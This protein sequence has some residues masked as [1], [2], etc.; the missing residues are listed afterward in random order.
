MGENAK[1][2]SPHRRDFA[3][4]GRE[5]FLSEKSPFLTS[6]KEAFTDPARTPPKQV[7]SPASQQKMP[8]WLETN[9]YA[10]EFVGTTNIQTPYPH[11]RDD[12]KE[13]GH[14]QSPERLRR[15]EKAKIP[16]AQIHMKER[17]WKR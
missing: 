10:D 14:T 4:K 9:R 15:A 3:A 5:K 11:L 17:G 6:H 7:K 12:T 2:Y 1:P 13:G 16:T 8:P